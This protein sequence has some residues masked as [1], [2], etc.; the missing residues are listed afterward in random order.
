VK[1]CGR[2]DSIDLLCQYAG[3]FRF[4]H[5]VRFALI[6]LLLISIVPLVKK[7]LLTASEYHECQSTKRHEN[8]FIVLLTI[9][10]VC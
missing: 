4:N 8:R 7:V 5:P 2:E 10:T 9:S 6:G 1:G 3:S